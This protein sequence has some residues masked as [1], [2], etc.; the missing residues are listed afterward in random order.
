LKKMMDKEKDEAI[1]LSKI[2]V[3][4]KTLQRASDQNSKMYA[5]IANRQKE[6]DIT[7]PMKVNNVRVLE[8]ATVPGAPIRPKPVQN[9]LIGLLIGFC[10][11]IALAFAI[12]ALD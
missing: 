11:G 5:I 9:L 7:G 2:E 3:D 8:R 12:E 6:I 10:T 4:Y 1:N